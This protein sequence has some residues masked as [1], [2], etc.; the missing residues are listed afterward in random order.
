M[1]SNVHMPETY[2]PS[3]RRVTLTPRDGE[4]PD[5]AARKQRDLDRLLSAADTLDEDW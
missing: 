1:C 5:V 4:N 3:P 2:S